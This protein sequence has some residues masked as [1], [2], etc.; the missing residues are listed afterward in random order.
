MATLYVCENC[1]ELVGMLIGQVCIP[2]KRNRLAVG[3]FGN[4][5]PGIIIVLPSG[6]QVKIDVSKIAKFAAERMTPG[7]EELTEPLEFELSEPVRP[8]RKF[9]ALK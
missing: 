8:L 2:C 7:G 9:R 4:G 5:D 3:E 6:R 1:G